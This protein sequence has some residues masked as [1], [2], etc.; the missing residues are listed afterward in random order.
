VEGTF[1][2]Q[3]R[4]AASTGFLGF[5]PLKTAQPKSTIAT[6]DLHQSR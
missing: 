3:R 6:I 4:G 2:V 5:S 1:I